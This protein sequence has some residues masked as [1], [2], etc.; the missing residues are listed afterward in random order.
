[1]MIIM[2]IIIIIA[3]RHGSD[4]GP[5]PESRASGARPADLAKHTIV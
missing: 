2:M 3:I 5:S 4:L 1:M